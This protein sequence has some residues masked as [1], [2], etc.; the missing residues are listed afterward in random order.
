[1]RARMFINT[2]AASI[3]GA[4][5]FLSGC[6]DSTGPEEKPLGEQ[7]FVIV[8]S[9]ENSLSLVPVNDTMPAHVVGLLGQNASPVSLAVHGTRAVVPL[10]L[11]HAASVVDLATR[12]V[13]RTIALEDNSG[14]TGAAFEN[15]SIAWIANPSLNTVTRVNVNSGDTSSVAVG[16][17]PQAVA[18]T[19]G[20]VWVAN[21]NLVMWAPAGPSWLT[22]ID[23][24]TSQVVDS[25]E[26]SG[27]NAAA[28]E[29]GQDGNL[30]VLNSGNFGAADGSL[31]VVDPVAASETGFLADIG[32]FPGS[33][34]WVSDELLVVGSFSDGIL[35]VDPTGPTLTRAGA[36]GI[37][38]EGAG[39]SGVG[40]DTAGV[41]YALNSTD[42]VAPGKLNAL[43][44]PGYDVVRTMD[45][46]VCPYAIERVW[47]RE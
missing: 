12:T 25:V 6:G 35:E 36:Q 3:V 20:K 10:G 8:N 13:E 45:T 39:V 47:I 19:A 41:V 38:P 37:M 5:F 18:Y 43:Q 30:Y 32:E 21:A 2:F 44:P 46:G 40:A 31:S 42:C 7:V 22:V 27:Q 11:A 23:P 1:M 33:L 15:D 24:A 14:A 29:L 34:V 9:T 4:A 28:L 16:V 17:Y 26:L